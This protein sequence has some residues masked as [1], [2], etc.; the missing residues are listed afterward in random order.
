METLCHALDTH[1]QKADLK[2]V[3]L[4]LSI[5]YILS[6]ENVPIPAFT[7]QEFF[8]SM[9]MD[10]F[11]FNDVDYSMLRDDSQLFLRQLE[12]QPEF[13]QLYLKVCDPV[14]EGDLM[15]TF[16]KRFLQSINQGMKGKETIILE[17]NEAVYERAL[18]LRQELM[19]IIQETEER[20]A[21]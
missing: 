19:Q 20:T 13:K 10:N 17:P 16:K 4:P 8:E 5:E 2:I 9:A 1:P 3:L 18:K 14:K 15:P 7:L 11:G 12:I 21:N 6:L